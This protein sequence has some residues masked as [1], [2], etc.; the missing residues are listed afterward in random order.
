MSGTFAVVAAGQMGA[1]VGA[2]LAE[3]GARVV[4]SAVG[5]S[6]ATA[7]RARAAGMVEVADAELAAADVFLSVVPPDQAVPLASR[8]AG[9]LAA[10]GRRAVYVDLNAVSPHTAGR[11]HQIVA[12][13]GA[14][15]V[16]GGIIGGPPAGG[17]AG[18]TVYL[19][20]PAAAWVADLLVRHGLVARALDGGIGTASALKMSYAGLTK[21]TTALGAA[22][23]L[24]ATRAGVAEPLRAEL[25]HSQPHVLA[26]LSTGLPGMLPKAY[27]WAPEMAEIADFIG[28][29]R[30][31]AEIYR[32]MASFYAALA[33]DH[34]GDGTA[35]DTLTDFAA[36][37]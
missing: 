1:A 11:V 19:S 26:R 21:G 32:A 22:M 2:R 31:E 20:G 36:K 13:A 6:E 7:G 8:L 16:D 28:D 25:A 14:T 10:V 24:A 18:P 15:F 37:P 12:A 23:V 33:A 29:G 4:T 34:D 17:S 35:A 5:R 27:R 30:P 3:R 9:P